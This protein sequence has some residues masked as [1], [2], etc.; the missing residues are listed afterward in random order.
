MRHSYPTMLCLMMSELL[1][2]LT[3]RLE[4]LRY[5]Y[6]DLNILI[7]LGMMGPNMPPPGPSGTPIGMQGQ[8]P[9][10]PPKSW[11]EGIRCLFCY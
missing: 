10:G 4:T 8:N 5:V 3:C 2:D 6:Y 11:P 7:C 1:I 9:N